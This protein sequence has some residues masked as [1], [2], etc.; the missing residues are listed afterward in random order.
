M[1]VYFSA[2]G[3]SRLIANRIAE[4]IGDKCISI[5]SLLDSG[6]LSLNLLNEECLGIVTP[7][8]FWGLPLIVKSF[9][10]NLH[11]DS[12]RDIYIYLVATYGTTTGAIGEITKNTLAIKGITLNAQYCVRMPDTWTPLFNLSD[13]EKN[14]KRLQKS[15]QELDDIIT[16][17][18]SRYHVNAMR[19]KTP[20]WLGKLYHKTY[21]KARETR[22]FHVLN[23]KCIGCGLCRQ[24]CPT[25]TINLIDGIPH[26][27]QKRCL[28]CLACLHHCP[29]FAIQYGKNTINHGQ[30]TCPG[31]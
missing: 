28:A 19:G 29:E 25:K 8:Y 31:F 1:I 17:I 7:T 11:I 3:N 5:R 9:L 22:H 14:A 12:P 4:S 18:K 20:L 2:T 23:E 16:A 13:K 21:D 30:Y 6:D 26:W 27:T 24:V 10:D 15:R